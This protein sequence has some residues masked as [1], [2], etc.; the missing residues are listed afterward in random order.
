MSSL[1]KDIQN[2][3]EE[4]RESEMYCMAKCLDWTNFIISE[5]LGT[6]RIKQLI[7]WLEIYIL[8]EMKQS[9]SIKAKA[10][11]DSSEILSTFNFST[12]SSSDFSDASQL[13]K[14]D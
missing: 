8:M 9:I 13:L 4:G 1:H 11:P 12:Y 14:K 10:F 5:E 6:R 2:T 3:V 7:M